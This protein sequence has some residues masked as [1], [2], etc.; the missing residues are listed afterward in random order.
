M[1]SVRRSMTVVA[2][3]SARLSNALTTPRFSATNTG[4]PPGAKRT[5]VG[6]LRPVSTGVALEAGRK[7]GGLTGGHQDRHNRRRAG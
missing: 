7:R 5:D 1:V 6:W 4:P 3:G 2:V